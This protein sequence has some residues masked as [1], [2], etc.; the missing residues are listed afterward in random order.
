MDQPKSSQVGVHVKPE[1]KY[2]DDEQMLLWAYRGIVDSTGSSF[3]LA[4]RKA[5]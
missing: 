1:E 3:C 5:S 4:G 2:A